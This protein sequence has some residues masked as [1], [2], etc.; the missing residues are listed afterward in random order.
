MTATGVTLPTF[1]TGDTERNWSA[2][3]LN[4]LVEQVRRLGNITV[5]PGL[6]VEY[7]RT[8][9]AIRL[10]GAVEAPLLAARFIVE[11][12]S[13]DGDTV[14]CK[15]S[16]S[17]EGRLK[18]WRPWLLRRTPFDAEVRNDIAYDYTS[19]TERIARRQDV[20]GN[21]TTENQIIIPRY[22][23]GDVIYAAR[24]VL[25]TESRE[26]WIDLNVDGRFWARKSE[27]DPGQV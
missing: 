24:G 18:V 20:E 4:H 2:R 13:D 3:E 5:G 1:N 8:G 27:N 19:N 26:E 12:A 9:V 25:A 14:T 6:H 23:Q 15:R 16:S 7:T 10:E 11:D 21:E 17:G 22:V